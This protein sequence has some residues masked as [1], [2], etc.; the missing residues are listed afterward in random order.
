MTPRPHKAAAGESGDD[1][2]D[3]ACGTSGSD[4]ADGDLA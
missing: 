2:E 4:C 1:E 3:A